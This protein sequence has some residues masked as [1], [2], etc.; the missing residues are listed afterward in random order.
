MLA[1]VIVGVVEGTT[2]DG[3]I[4]TFVVVTGLF[5]GLA[6]FLMGM[7]RMT[8][9]LRVI[10]GD[11]MRSILGRLTVNRFAA[12]GTGAGVTAVIQSSSVTTV[13]VVGFITAGLMTLQQSVGVIMGANV[14]TTITAQ[15]IAFKVSRYALGMIALGFILRLVTKNERRRSQGDLILGLGLVFFGMAVMGDAMNPLGESEAFRDW[16]AGMDN[17]VSGILAGAIF[18]AVIQSSSATTGVVLALAFEG[19]ITLDAGIALILGANIGTSVTAQLAAIGK[20]PDAH[21]A[22]WVHTLFNVLGVVIWIPFISQLAAIVES[23]GGGLARQIAN[24]HT[25]FNVVNTLIF[26]WF[27]RQ[28][29]DLAYRLVPEK[30][31]APVVMPKYLDDG[32]IRTPSIALD[33]AR[34]ELLRLSQRVREMLADSIPAVL[35]G[36]G[37]DL[38]TIEA[39]DDEVDSLY[40][41]I[42][43]YLGRLSKQELGSSDSDELFQLMEATNNLE[44]IGDIIETNLV[45]LGLSRLEQDLVVSKETSQ[46]I[47]KFHTKI[48]DAYELAMLAVTQKNEAA[49]HRCAAMKSTINSMARKADEFEAVR[50]VA[51]E[52]NRVAN[53]AFETDVIAHLKRIYW[54]TRRTARV[55][56]PV[57]ERSDG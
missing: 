26:I 3:S 7:D 39:M 5:G 43:S 51:D 29:A 27:T 48:L 28:F 4:D 8:R 1:T 34:L 11:R 32:L 45:Q 15:I 35:G 50:L 53:Y 10:A 18:T 40:G 31:E 2:S 36:T 37:D 6:L 55:A 25:I 17:P 16:M 41:S 12:A 14:G 52:P 33:R 23:L 38:I 9:S 30:P 54:F 42:V 46:L 56:V 20:P 47:E 24:A 21:R 44:A 49:A 57:P 22:A 13:L 19:L